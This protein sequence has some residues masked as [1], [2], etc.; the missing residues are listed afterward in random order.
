MDDAVDLRLF[1]R[2]LPQARQAIRERIEHVQPEFSERGNLV[3]FLGKRQRQPAPEQRRGVTH[4]QRQAVEQGGLAHAAR[5]GQQNVLRRRV[6]V[7]F[8]QRR[9]QFLQFEIPANE[10]AFQF[11][12]AQ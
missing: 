5:A 2:E 3:L 10:N 9:D 6:R 1:G 4:F 11:F 12:F 7:G 8:L